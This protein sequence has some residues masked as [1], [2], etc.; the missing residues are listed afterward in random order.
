MNMLTLFAGF[1]AL[2]AR[3]LADA[4]VPRG[5]RHRLRERRRAQ[6]AFA[7]SLGSLQELGHEV[8][9]DRHV[10]EHEVLADPHGDVH[11][12]AYGHGADP[13]H[14]DAHG[15]EAAH[16]HHMVAQNEASFA[17]AITL[18]ASII[19]QMSLTYLLNNKDEDI[20]K[21]SYEVLSEII[22][23]FCS[24]LIFQ[25]ANGI[26]MEIFFFPG[27]S[28]MWVFCVG[29][30]HTIAWFIVLQAVLAYL[31]GVIPGAKRPEKES[32]R[33]VPLKCWALLLAHITGFSGIHLVGEAQ[34]LFCPDSPLWCFLVVLISAVVLRMI[35]SIVYAM[36]A[37][38]LTCPADHETKEMWSEETAEAENDLM[39]L[40]ISFTLVQAIRFC[41]G[42]VLPA[43]NGHESPETAFSHTTPQVAILCCSGLL[44]LVVRFLAID[45][46]VQLSQLGPRMIRTI[47][48]VSLVCAMSFAWC[49][50]YGS[51]WFVAAFAPDMFEANDTALSLILAF[52]LSIMSFIAIFFFD[53]LADLE[54]T[55]AE[56]DIPLRDLLKVFGFLIGFAWEQTFDVALG[57]IAQATDRPNITMPTLAMLS[58][59]ILVPAW[60]YYILPMVLL[61]GWK[62]GFIFDHVEAR[63][64]GL[65]ALKN[66]V[67]AFFVAEHEQAHAKSQRR[68][69]SALEEPSFIGSM[70]VYGES[71]A[72]VK[73]AE[74]VAKGK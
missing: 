9:A 12:D 16:G 4:G 69:T 35:L 17:I 68:P 59:I 47:D 5:G 19:F 40:S 26:V 20:R 64:G 60:R 22:S 14:A 18:M 43:V 53:W 62:F 52:G 50:Y 8:V 25:S 1:L 30:G 33:H 13:H 39:A 15:H 2:S 45:Y 38:V 66:H 70:L 23:I 61:G 74:R 54:C 67:D 11:A 34:Q 36:R 6:R 41:I 44:F 72:D 63:Y 73:E 57:T 56:I 7:L 55:S 65:N 71:A 51:R 48:L 3:A 32:D 28:D 29:L 46:D 27:C 49:I 58:V 10:D 21:S 42:G 31:C 24:V 37:R